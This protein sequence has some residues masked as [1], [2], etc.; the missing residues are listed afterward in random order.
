MRKEKIV[1]SNEL[2]RTI[3]HKRL[4]FENIFQITGTIFE[5]DEKQSFSSGFC[6]RKLILLTDDYNPEPITFQF[7]NSKIDLLNDVR[8]LEKV[9]IS[10]RLQGQ[11]WKGKYI[12]NIIA[13]D[14]KRDAQSRILGL[15]DSDFFGDIKDS[16]QEEINRT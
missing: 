15:A 11:S 6:V 3:C 4:V 7:L 10:F 5:I 13:N 9:C 8:L 16:V 1:S 12:T 14:L 2:S